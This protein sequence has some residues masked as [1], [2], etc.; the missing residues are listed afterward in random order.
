MEINKLRCKFVKNNNTILIEACINPCDEKGSKPRWTYWY[1][2][3]LDNDK[4]EQIANMIAHISQKTWI[5]HNYLF[6]VE[7]LTLWLCSL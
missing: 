5:R 4:P 6:F 1:E 7:L 2:I 3:D